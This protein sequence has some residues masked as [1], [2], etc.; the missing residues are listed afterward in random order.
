[1]NKRNRTRILIV[2]IAMIALLSNGTRTAMATSAT[3]D[4][5][6]SLP[7]ADAVLYVN[8]NLLLEDVLPRLFADNPAIFA[9]LKKGLD[10][11]K[12]S[13]G[14]DLSLIDTLAIGVRFNKDARQTPKVIVIA[15][16]RFDAAEVLVNANAKLKLNERFKTQ[17]YNNRTIYVEAAPKYNI[18]IAPLGADTFVSGDPQMVH[19]AIDC[20][21]SAAGCA[22]NN[23]KTLAASNKDALF[24]YAGNNRATAVFAQ[25]LLGLSSDLSK[26]AASVQEFNGSVSAPGNAAALFLSARTETAEQAEG[27]A[28]LF[29]LMKQINESP[30]EV[31]AQ[32]RPSMIPFVDGLNELFL[33]F[34]GLSVTTEGSQVR[35]SVEIPFARIMKFMHPRSIANAPP[36]S[37]PRAAP[38]ARATLRRSP[39]H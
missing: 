37:P 25:M 30:D 38:P 23:L 32:K 28:Q 36:P 2:A 35:F 14:F 26:L 4:A 20:N 24:G 29:A 33:L 18:A 3:D 19:D 21:A 12:T 31:G 34:K 16:G 9:E 17:A 7:A 6:A 39:R 11:A 13:T 5:L 22:E 10:D 1:M 15:R 27:I 8:V